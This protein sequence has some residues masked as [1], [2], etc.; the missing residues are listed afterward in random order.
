MQLPEKVSRKLRELPDK[1]GCYM[2]RNAAGRIIYVGKAISLRRRVQS[3]FR[4][5]TL[6]SASP[7]VRG[8]VRMVADIDVIVV[9]N[10]AEALLTEA[11][12]IKDYR[13]R[14]NISFKDDKRYLMIRIQRGVPLPRFE[15]CRIA[16]E[17]GADY[18]GPYVSSAAARVTVDFVEKRFGIRKCTPRLPGEEEYRHCINDIVRFCSAPCVNRITP[19]DYRARVDA[20]VAFLRGESPELLKELRADMEAAAGKQDFEK[21]AALR[22]TLR[23]LH[24]TVKQRARMSGDRRMQEADATRGIADLQTALGLPRLPR[25][26]E[27]FDISNTAGT[28][29]VAS[30]VCAVNGLPR[31]NR[32]KRFRIKTVVGADDPRSMGEVVHRRYARLKEEGAAMPD[33]VLIDGGVTQLR[34]ARE[35]LDALGLA[36]LPSAGLAKRF[37]EIHWV[38]GEEPL[39]LPL[40]S[41]ALKVLRRLRDEA[42]RFAL[43]YHRHLRSQ[44]IRAS[45]L[46][47]VPGI[48]QKR[49]EQILQHFGSVRRLMRA[50]VDQLCQV[51]GIGRATAERIHAE[52]HA[53]RPTEGA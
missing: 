23:S 19:E 53:G 1:P 4:Q 40:D 15:V 12:L 8:M 2:M 51:P 28:Y 11:Q 31:R 45:A 46:D 44:R 18:F 52:L 38:D 41:P 48:G 42:H 30:M 34:A 32:Y 25:V 50:G 33:L 16:R 49:K 20:A 13:P 14:Y 43:T 9:R 22:D 26:I 35:A 3:Y 10:E 36:R 47:A 21:A 37:E 39:R 5:S 6:R 7:K 24:D 29:S 27:A 17:D